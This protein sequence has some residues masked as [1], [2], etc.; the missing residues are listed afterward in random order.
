MA[1]RTRKVSLSGAMLG[2]A[3]DADASLGSHLRLEFQ[4]IGTIDALFVRRSAAGTAV[5]FTGMEEG[6]REQLIRHLYT[7]G[8]EQ[9]TDAS[10]GFAR[11]ST[12][13]FNRLV[14]AR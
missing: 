4:A 13:I 11:R 2:L 12:T 8:L 7:M 9:E 5:R 6:T 10:A 14:G 3:S 1:G